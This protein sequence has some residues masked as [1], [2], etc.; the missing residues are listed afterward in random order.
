M[1]KS[2]FSAVLVMCGLLAYEL[3]TGQNVLDSN[4]DQQSDL[5]T[6]L[7]LAGIIVPIVWPL[8]DK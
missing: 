2:I 6:S 5:Y 4:W 8:F 7:L 1:F 3:I